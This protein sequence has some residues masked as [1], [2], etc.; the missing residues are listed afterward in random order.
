MR[1]RGDG[2]IINVTSVAGRVLAAARRH[3]RRLRSSRLEG[4]SRGAEARGRATSASRSRRRAR[5]LR[6][7]VLRTTPGASGRTR[8]PTTSSSGR[9]ARHG[10]PRGAG[11]RPARGPK[12]VATRSPTSSSP[13]APGVRGTRWAT[14][15]QMVLGALRP[16]GRRHV[17]GDDASD[18]RARLVTAHGPPAAPARVLAVYAHPD[19][20]EISAGGTLARWAAEG[21]EVWVLVTTRGDKGTAIPTSIPTRS[22]RCGWRRPRGGRACSGSPGTVTSTMATASSRTTARCA[23]EIVRV[24]RELRPDVVLCPDPTAVFFGDGYFNHRDH[25]VTG[26][27]TLDAIAPAAGQPALLPRAARRGPD[28]APGARGLPLGHAR[29]ELLGRHLRARSSARSTRCSATQSQLAGDGELVPRVPPPAGRA[30]RP[31]GR[32]PL[33]RRPLLRR[34]TASS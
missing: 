7:R 20:P 18:A 3:V 24:V 19:D 16:D 1:E 2:T 31:P 28:R 15:P 26:W 8:R 17:R 29:A 33:R 4:L 12:T 10:P 22:P 13:S 34:L 5:V 27:A 14:T 21:A 32:R 30:R 23:S 25:R 11:P 6:D 9:G